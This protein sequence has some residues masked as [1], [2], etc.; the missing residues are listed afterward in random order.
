M[1]ALDRFSQSAA[2]DAQASVPDLSH[3]D[4]QA[5]VLMQDADKLAKQLE[6]KLKA[7]CELNHAGEDALIYMENVRVAIKS[8]MQEIGQ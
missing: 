4:Y 6:D 8:A 5:F 2:E 7:S 3:W 1:N